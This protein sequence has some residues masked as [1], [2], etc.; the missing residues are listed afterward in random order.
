MRAVTVVLNRHDRSFDSLFS[1]LRGDMAAHHTILRTS[2][3]Y[4]VL[5]VNGLAQTSVPAHAASP[6]TTMDCWHIRRGARVWPGSCNP[7]SGVGSIDE[8]SARVRKERRDQM[9]KSVWASCPC[10]QED[11]QIY[12]GKWT[13]VCNC[14]HMLYLGPTPIRL[15][16]LGKIEYPSEGLMV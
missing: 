13:L 7:A 4:R 8:S 3:K 2:P 14:G 5:P 15:H 6:L 11:I 16:F 12:E 1:E 9:G 10:C